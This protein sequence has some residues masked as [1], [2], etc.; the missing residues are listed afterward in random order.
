MPRQALRR[1]F[2]HGMLPQ[3]MVFEAV[4]R[5]GSVTRAAEELHLAQPT[6]STQ[7]SKLAEALDVTLLEQRG[8]KLF[9]TPAGRVL[10]ESCDELIELLGRADARLEPFRQGATEAE[11]LHLAAE[12]E[13]REVAARLLAAFCARHPGAQVTLQIAERAQLLTRFAAG[14]DDVYLFGLEVDDLPSAQRWSLLHPRG[15]PLPE[16]ALKFLREALL[17]DAPPARANNSPPTEEG[18]WRSRGTTTRR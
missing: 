1:Y 6:V 15:R 13:A 5:L 3:L 7:L 12:P 8:R 16:A 17:L 10:Q 18:E 9:L 4:A 2:R 14:E 11:T